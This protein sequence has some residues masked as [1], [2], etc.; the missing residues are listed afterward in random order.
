MPDQNLS[1]KMDQRKRRI[2][3]LEAKLPHALNG[4]RPRFEHD[5]DKQR[6]ALRLLI[7][8]RD[9]LACSCLGAVHH[10]A[11]HFYRRNR[12]L[13][14]DDLV[15][16]GMVGLVLAA[17]FYRPG[18]VSK[19]RTVCFNTYASACI[20]SHLIKECKR[21]RSLMHVPHESRFPADAQRAARV[22]SLDFMHADGSESHAG[23]VKQEEVHHEND[24]VEALLR[25][26]AAM[27][28]NPHSK[29][30]AQ[31]IRLRWL[32]KRGKR[33]LRCVA[34]QLRLSYERVRQIEEA[35]LEELRKRMYQF[36]A[37]EE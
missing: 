4:S 32:G 6:Q 20:R 15:G 26:L 9:Q 17:E 2:A 1:E 35:G 36:I 10:Q 7:A 3:Q 28:N 11:L 29:K 31:V 8:Q 14:L 37:D 18:T 19:G 21:Q 16:A 33:T 30:R 27:E 34:A 12:H 23:E 22:L 5:L 13:D 24:Q 25:H